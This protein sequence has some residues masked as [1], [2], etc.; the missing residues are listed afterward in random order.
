MHR[1]EFKEREQPSFGV[2]WKFNLSKLITSAVGALDKELPIQKVFCWTD[3]TIALAWIKAVSK[4][5][6]TIVQS[7]VSSIRQKVSNDQWYYCH[8][9][10]RRGDDV[11]SNVVEWPEFLCHPII[12]AFNKSLNIIVG[13]LNFNRSFQAI[14]RHS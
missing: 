9:I 13:T 1:T 4:E 5:F 3:S 8:I 11:N 6:K 2:T 10:T 14:L 12:N 7:W